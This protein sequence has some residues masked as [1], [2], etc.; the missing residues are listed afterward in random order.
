MLSSMLYSLS[1]PQWGQGKSGA[2][3]LEAQVCRSD[4]VRI[5]PKQLQ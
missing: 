2:S 1:K 3:I 4:M 5:A